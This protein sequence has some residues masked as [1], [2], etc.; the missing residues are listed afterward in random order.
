M[1]SNRD[2]LQQIQMGDIVQFIWHVGERREVRKGIVAGWAT[3]RYERRN[4]L[5]D[6]DRCRRE[7]PVPLSSVV[8]RTRLRGADKGVMQWQDSAEDGMMAV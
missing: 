5:V 8:S 6:D 2:K 3:D 4:L 7:T 1:T